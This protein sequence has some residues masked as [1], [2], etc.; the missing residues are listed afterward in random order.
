MFNVPFF[1]T[2]EELSRDNWNIDFKEIN[3]LR[4]NCNWLRSTHEGTIY[5]ASR[6]QDIVI[7]LPF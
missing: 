3:I 1:L 6:L 7:P 2:F 4:I 5:D